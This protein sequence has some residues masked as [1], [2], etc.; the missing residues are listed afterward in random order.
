MR[1]FGLWTTDSASFVM[2]LGVSNFFSKGGK[3]FAGFLLDGMG[4]SNSNVCCW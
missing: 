2:A 1:M 3:S 4:V